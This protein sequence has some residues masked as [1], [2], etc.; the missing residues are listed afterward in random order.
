MIQPKTE[1]TAL[2]HRV[3]SLRRVWW[4]IVYPFA[5]VAHR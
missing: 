4:R 5:V 2:V 1:P 3:V